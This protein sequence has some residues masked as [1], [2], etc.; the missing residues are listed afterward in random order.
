MLSLILHLLIDASVVVLASNMMTTVH[1]RSFKTA[2]GVAILIA[3]FS[4][5]LGWFF[6]LIL[7]IASLGLFYF[8]GLGIITR[9]IAYSII[10]QIVSNLKSGFRTDGFWASFGLAILL[11]LVGAVLDGV[12]L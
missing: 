1:V 2:F 3:L 10:I 12:I 8:L 7:D 11:A 9:T 6:T 5:F 4:F